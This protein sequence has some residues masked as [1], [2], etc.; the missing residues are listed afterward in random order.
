[1]YHHPLDDMLLCTYVNDFLLAA[2]SLY[3]AQRSHHHFSLQYDCKFFTARTCVGIDI[4]LDLDASKMYLSQATLNNRL[5]EQ[6]L[7]GIMC[8]EQLTSNG[9][10]YNP[11]KDLHKWEQQFYII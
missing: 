9:F 10:Q 11:G 5:L 4:I 8:S 2:S 1:M 6:K 3:L 7:G